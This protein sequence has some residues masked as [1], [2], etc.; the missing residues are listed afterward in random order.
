MI[1]RIFC[2]ILAALALCA[3]AFAEGDEDIV[4]L[5]VIAR[6]DSQDDQAFKFTVR[7]AVL[8][9]LEPY[10]RGCADFDDI[11]EALEAGTADAEAAARGA[12]Q[13]AG[14]DAPIHVETGTFEFDAREKDGRIFPAGEYRA[15]RVVIGEGE[16]CNWWGIMYPDAMPVKA[17]EDAIYYSAIIEWLMELFGRG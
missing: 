3:P 6:S 9:A 16:G 17:D 4:R 13:R 14:A 7:D 15:M 5:H 12:A 10:L 11:F 8:E 2:G 1:K